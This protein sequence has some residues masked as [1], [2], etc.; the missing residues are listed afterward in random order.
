MKKIGIST[1]ELQS[2]FGDKGA[3]DVALQAGADAIDFFT[4]QYSVF[5]PDTIFS[6]SDEEIVEYIK[7]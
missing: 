5:A 3:I 7:E 1:Y 6:K 2:I 4:N